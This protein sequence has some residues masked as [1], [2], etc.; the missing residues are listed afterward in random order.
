MYVGVLI[1]F[2]FMGVLPTCISD[3]RLACC[4]SKTK[5]GIGLPGTEVTNELPHGCWKSN[6]GLGR[7]AS[8]L[9]FEPCL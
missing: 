9:T 8:A 4:L 3:Y 1:F 7:T 5:E 2:M 6:L